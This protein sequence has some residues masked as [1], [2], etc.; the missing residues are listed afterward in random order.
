MQLNMVWN[1]VGVGAWSLELGAWSFPTVSQ[2]Q[3]RS[4]FS[5][6]EREA[7]CPLY[8]FFENYLCLSKAGKTQ[9]DSL[10]GVWKKL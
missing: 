3:G 7:D 1:R 10:R 4:L 6:H 9:S 5:S 8:F 2:G